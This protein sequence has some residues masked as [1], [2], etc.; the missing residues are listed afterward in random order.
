LSPGRPG[1]NLTP[2]VTISPLRI[3]HPAARMT[4]EALRAV[5]EELGFSQA[6][7][8]RELKLTRQ[9][10]SLW[11]LGDRQIPELAWREILRVRARFEAQR[12]L[13]GAGD[14]APGPC[15]WA[16][17]WGLHGPPDAAG[18][19]RHLETCSACTSALAWLTARVG[20]GMLTHE[21]LRLSGAR[22]TPGSTG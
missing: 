11:E 15:S 2:A 1:A 14:T 7:L 21:T 13:D 12:S 8:A 9:A 17:K 20:L 4:P 10:V 18:F 19:A 22:P 5:R 6:R 3:P 16:M